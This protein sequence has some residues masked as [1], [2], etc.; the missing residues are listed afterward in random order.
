[1]SD[2]TSIKLHAGL[3]VDLIIMNSFALPWLKYLFQSH[4]KAFIMKTKENALLH[5]MVFTLK[6]SQWY[7]NKA[8]RLTARIHELSGRQVNSPLLTAHYQKGRSRPCDVVS[9]ESI[10]RHFIFSFQNEP[11]SREPRIFFRH[12]IEGVLSFHIFYKSRRTSLEITM[13][14]SAMLAN[15]R[16]CCC[17]WGP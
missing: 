12:I 1:M 5:N 3:I 9:I 7:M 6:A 16:F 14:W 11:A 10:D 15:F 8:W 13:E 17:I 2:R 4:S